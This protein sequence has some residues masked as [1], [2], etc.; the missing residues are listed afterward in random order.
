M[1]TLLYSAKSEFIMAPHCIMVPKL[2]PYRSLMGCYANKVRNRM[3]RPTKLR[4]EVNWSSGSPA[5]H[6]RQNQSLYLSLLYSNQHESSLNT[7]YFPLVQIKASLPELY[8]GVTL[9]LLANYPRYVLVNTTISYWIKSA[10][11]VFLWELLLFTEY[12]ETISL[13]QKILLE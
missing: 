5:V 2:N 9:T 13:S 3:G 12:S 10:R 7:Y 1:N 4:C 8:L 11:T 6:A